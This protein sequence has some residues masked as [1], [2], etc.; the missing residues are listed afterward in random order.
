MASLLSGF[1]LDPLDAPQR[2]CFHDSDDEDEV[3]QTFESPESL[4]T[5]ETASKASV[6]L[7][8]IGTSPITC[9]F[10]SSHV[11]TEAHTCSTVKTHDSLK[12]L[13]GRYFP[14]NSDRDLNPAIE[15]IISKIYKAKDNEGTLICTNEESLKEDYANGW[16]QKVCDAPPTLVCVGVKGIC[17]C[18]AF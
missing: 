13:K 6:D 8:V 15:T 3:P 12:V 14:S 18:I 5:V 9:K 16:S 7:L 17:T 10:L 4:F 2:H 1:S 11:I